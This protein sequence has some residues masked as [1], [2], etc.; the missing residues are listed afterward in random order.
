MKRSPREQLIFLAAILLTAAPFAFALIRAFQTGSDLR[1]L[2]VAIAAFIGTNVVIAAG[3]ARSRTTSGVFIL[4]TAATVLGTIVAG[5]SARFM[6]NTA[7]AAAWMVALFFAFCFAA[8][9]ALFAF[10]RPTGN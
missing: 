10:S 7:S 9:S 4:T 5:L 1:Y 8:G 6:T 3:K 2:W